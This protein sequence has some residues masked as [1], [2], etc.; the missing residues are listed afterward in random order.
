MSEAK[1]ERLVIRTNYGS[2]C[3]EALGETPMILLPSD[4]QLLGRA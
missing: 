1:V 3:S 2:L 4:V